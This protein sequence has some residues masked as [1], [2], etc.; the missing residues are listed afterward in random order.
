MRRR[1][2]NDPHSSPSTQSALPVA[3]DCLIVLVPGAPGNPASLDP[4]K[5]LIKSKF[6]VTESN[7]VAFKYLANV[8]SNQDCD[9][10]ARDF[11][12]FVEENFQQKREKLSR[13]VIVAHSMGTCL[14][15]RAFLNGLGFRSSP[16]AEH[17]WPRHV[18]RFVL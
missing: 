6:D 5:S 1:F 2:M 4:L 9:D 13:I 8:T 7:F 3:N 11:S 18:D 10:L 14:A 15:R 16:I 12:A 17:E